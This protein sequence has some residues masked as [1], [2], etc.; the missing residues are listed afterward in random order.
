M[1]YRTRNPTP[2]RVRLRV[3]ATFEAE[4]EETEP[5]SLSGI[6]T[7]DTQGEEVTETKLAKCQ[8]EERRKAVGQ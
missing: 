7:Y 1:T 3:V 2:V 4:Y 5:P 6:P 8:P